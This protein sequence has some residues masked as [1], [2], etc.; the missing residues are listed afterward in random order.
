M[1][2][3]LVF[4]K[5]S[6]FKQI[7]AVKIQ[8]NL[9]TSHTCWRDRTPSVNDFDRCWVTFLSPRQRMAYLLCL[10]LSTT[11]W[12]KPWIE[13]IIS[14]HLQRHQKNGHRSSYFFRGKPR[15]FC[16]LLHLSVWIWRR[17]QETKVPTVRSHTLPRMF[18][19]KLDIFSQCYPMSR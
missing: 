15:E 5:D 19:G 18:K 4:F 10:R 2:I 16:Y 9:K 12:K 14:S 8:E 7:S 1:Y 11:S 3:F 13:I 6:I 17:N